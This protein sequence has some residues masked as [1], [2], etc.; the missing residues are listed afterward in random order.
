MGNG[1][2]ARVCKKGPFF[3]DCGLMFG[4][5]VTQQ[6][7]PIFGNF[8]GTLTL[9]MHLSVERICSPCPCPCL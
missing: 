5:D 2:A 7:Y 1:P 8:E 4:N 9:R 3:L 6:N